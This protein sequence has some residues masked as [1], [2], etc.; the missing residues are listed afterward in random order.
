MLRRPL[1][2]TTYCHL[3]RTLPILNDRLSDTDAHEH[4]IIIYVV[5]ILALIAILFGDYNV[6]KMYAAGLSAIIRLRGG[7]DAIKNNPL[8]QLSIDRY[9]SSVQ[10][11]SLA[12]IL[13]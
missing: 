4:D 9:K 13:I 1:S 3:R 11:P 12:R 10:Q 7:I 6:A 8:I 5:S 2:N